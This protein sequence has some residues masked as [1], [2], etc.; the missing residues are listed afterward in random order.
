MMAAEL[1]KV[2][3][4]LTT[5]PE[6]IMTP[7]SSFWLG[8]LLSEVRG[9]HAHSPADDSHPLPSSATVVIIGKLTDHR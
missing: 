1:K 2:D 4:E 9:K 5:S 6:P 8:E 7:S 3:E